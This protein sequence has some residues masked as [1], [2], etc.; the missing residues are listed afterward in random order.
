M[1]KTTETK[2]NDFIS[3]FSD[4]AVWQVDSL[5]KSLIKNIVKDEL[6]TQ[7]S[8][9]DLLAIRTILDS[10][11]ETNHL[12]KE[13]KDTIISLIDKSDYPK[14]RKLALALMKFNALCEHDRVT[15]PFINWC[16]S[17]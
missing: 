12:S 1:N 15:Q 9:P 10:R 13:E 4:K 11:T 3:R 2:I 16:Y 6:K 8:D 14:Y 7:E 5:L 17:Y